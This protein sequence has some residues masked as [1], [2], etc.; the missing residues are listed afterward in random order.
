MRCVYADS[1]DEPGRWRGRG[2]NASGLVGEVDPEDFARVLAGRD[3]HT[4]E[5]LITAQGSAGRRPRLGVGAETRRSP[6]GEALYDEND[7]AA[8]LGLTQAEVARLLNVG[9]RLAVVRLIE[10]LTVGGDRVPDHRRGSYLVPFVGEDGSRWLTESELSR[11]EA[12]RSVGSSPE[13]VA[14]TAIPTTCSLSPK[15]V[16]WPASPPATCVP[17]AG[18]GR[19]ID[20]RSRRPW[21]RAGRHDGLTWWRIAG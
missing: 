6:G 8:F 3:P 17:S 12:A 14:L 9:E 20:R 7:A 19:N 4:G 1:S 10:H 13:A 15:P 2:A 18:T 5:R 21:P 16:G 11:C